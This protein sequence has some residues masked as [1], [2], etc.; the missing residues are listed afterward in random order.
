LDNTL[1]AYLS[2]KLTPNSTLQQQLQTCVFVFFSAIAMMLLE[3]T[4]ARLDAV[5]MALVMV[6]HGYGDGCLSFHRK[7]DGSSFLSRSTCRTAFRGDEH[8]RKCL[9]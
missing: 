8:Y 5:K 3:V 6:L 1:K 9:F 2:L 4:V 7:A